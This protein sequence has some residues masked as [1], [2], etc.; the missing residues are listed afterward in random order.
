MNYQNEERKKDHFIS[1]LA[2]QDGDYKAVIESEF[3][4]IPY[5]RKESVRIL[6]EIQNTQPL[7]RMSRKDSQAG[8]IKKNM[9]V[10]SQL[11]EVSE[12]K[13]DRF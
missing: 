8:S 4:N 13:S 10:K 3:Q 1:F 6:G 5:E 9:K 12:Y 11:V 7:Q 2:E